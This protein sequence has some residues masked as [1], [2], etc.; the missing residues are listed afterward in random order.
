MPMSTFTPPCTPDQGMDVDNTPRFI[1][2]QFGD[3][4]KQEIPDGINNLQAKMSPRWTNA[5]KTEADAIINFLKPLARSRTPFY[6]TPN[7]ETVARALKCLG[8]KYAWKKGRYCDIT[9]EFEET[10]AIA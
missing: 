9:A 2:A 7:G 10:A 3:G 1:Q 8:L 6:W 5:R 4:Y